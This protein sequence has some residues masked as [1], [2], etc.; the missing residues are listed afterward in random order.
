MSVFGLVFLTVCAR[1]ADAVP[2]LEQRLLRLAEEAEAFAATAP[3]IIG[4][5]TLEQVAVLPM[6]RFQPRGTK[7]EIPYT[8]RKLTSEYGF[9]VFKEDSQNLH[10]IREVLSVD[11]RQVKGPGKLRETLSMGLNTDSDRMKKKLLKEFEGYGLREAATDFGQVILLFTKRQLANYTFRP[12]RTGFIG[13]ERALVVSYEQIQGKSAMTV[14]EGKLV[15]KHRL[16]GELWM[17]D[18]D[19]VPLRITM[20]VSRLEK[21]V[22][23][24]HLA[25]VDYQQSAHGIVLPASIIYAEAVG[26][27]VMIENRFRYSGFRMF[28]ASSDVKFTVEPPQK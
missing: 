2:T 25:V 15:V 5:E 10:E 18:S 24:R 14:F 4:Q 21:N 20:D 28:G 23:L 22:P 19:G 7:P 11:G 9:A 17:R 16:R 1:A 12:L 26:S 8:S 27:Q 3:K 13:A 6:P